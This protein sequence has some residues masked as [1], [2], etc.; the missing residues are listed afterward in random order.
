MQEPREIELKLEIR[1]SQVARLRTRGL[2]PLGA[3]VASERLSSVYYDT[4][5]HALRNKGL[6]L[7][8]RSAAD[9]HVQTIKAES[10]A[11]A[12]IFD[13]PEWE[14]EV[15]AGEPDLQAASATPAG[16]VLSRKRGATLRPIF[17]TLV[18]RATWRVETETS[19]IEIAL[20]VGEVLAN[21]SAEPLAELELELKRGTAADLFRLA[22]SLDGL[23]TAKIAVL[24]K[25]ERGYAL[26]DDKRPTSF[27]A[28]KVAL[29]R[30][31]STGEAFRTIARSCI[32]HFRLN[33]PRVIEARS[34]EALHQCRVAMRRLRSA[35]SLFGD[36]VADAQLDR[37]K[38]RLR[39]VSTQLGQARNLDVYLARAARPEKER[40]PAEPGIDDF[41]SRLEAERNTAYGR[42]VALL[43][44]RR[45]R[46]LMLDL[47]AWIECGPWSLDEEPA[48]RARRDRLVEEFAAEVLD[49][50][51]R[52]VKRKGRNVAELDPEGRHRVR[53]DAKKLRYASEFFAALVEGKKNRKRHAAFICALEA[54]QSCLGELNDIQT[55][56]EMVAGLAQGDEG[57]ETVGPWLFAAGHV[58]GEQDGREHSLL[59]SAA[60]AHR[61]FVKAKPFWR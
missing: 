5:K 59:E 28:G 31:M 21:G 13:R 7:R 19:E 46:R 34:A 2:I 39:E 24:S 16:R 12:G 53:I 6:T 37:I 55:G 1:P 38:R 20:D 17:E 3:E 25:S 10:G 11:G 41:I 15:E 23:G 51:R 36:V 26:A 14:T 50:R 8:I 54:L 33:E 4:P 32:R 40:D 48:V 35:L 22:R 29:E 58:I 44:S 18:E 9:R 47:V 42:V 57:A 30:D 49:R 56:H 27:K 61:A 45:F 43:E 60:K 52:K